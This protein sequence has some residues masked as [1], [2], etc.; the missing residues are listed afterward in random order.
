VRIT[1]QGS[2]SHTST[3]SFIRITHQRL[4]SFHNDIHNKFHILFFQGFLFTYDNFT[5]L[6][7]TNKMKLL[8]A[9]YE[10]KVSMSTSY[11]L[12]GKKWMNTQP[13]SSTSISM[14]QTNH[15]VPLINF[16]LSMDPFSIIWNLGFGQVYILDFT[17]LLTQNSYLNYSKSTFM[18]LV[19][20]NSL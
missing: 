20:K 10:P 12:E 9:N 16:H 17:L 1:P 4:Q 3:H 18:P 5:S 8:N 6:D 7:L 15:Q 11:I 2:W 13:H 19:K 14:Y